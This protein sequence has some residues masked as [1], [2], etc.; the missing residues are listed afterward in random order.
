MPHNALVRL[1]YEGATDPLLWDAFLTK[2]AEAV[3]SET[4]GLLTPG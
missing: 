3:H 1:I 2:F 4:A